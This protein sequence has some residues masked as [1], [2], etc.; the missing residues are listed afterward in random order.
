MSL[1]ELFCAVDDFYRRL[2]PA[3]QQQQLGR[4]PRQ[5]RGDAIETQR[6]KFPG[7]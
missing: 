7:I 5:R 3:W 4:G 6:T 2:E 1:L